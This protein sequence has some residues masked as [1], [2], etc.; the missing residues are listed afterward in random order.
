MRLKK[1]KIINKIIRRNYQNFLKNTNKIQ[2]ENY[3]LYR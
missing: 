1:S 3:E 2:G